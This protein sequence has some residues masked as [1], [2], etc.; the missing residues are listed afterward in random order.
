MRKLIAMLIVASSPLAAAA[1]TSAYLEAGGAQ[2]TY[3]DTA[4]VTAGTLSG[5]VNSM[6]R[7]TGFSALL[8]GSSTQNS[9]WTIFGAADGSVFT[10]ALRGLRAELHGGGSGTTYGSNTGSGQ[11]VGGAR[12]HLAGQRVGAWAGASAGTVV[13]PF[14]ARAMRMGSAAVWA[15]FGPSVAQLS[16]TPVRI[17]GG[18][19]YTDTEA[20]FRFGNARLELGAVGGF[21][22]D[23]VGYEDSP[24]S[25]AS[26]NAT[27]WLARAVG[28]TAAA[29]SY[30][31]DIGQGLPSAKYI[32]LGVRV[33]P[34]RAIPTSPQLPADHILRERVPITSDL[35]LSPEANGQRTITFR[36]PSARRVE[37]MGDFTDWAP[38]EMRAGRAPGTWV[39]TLPLGTGVRQ[40]NVRIDGGEWSVPAGLATVRDEFGGSVGVL[41][42]Q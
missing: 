33:A 38:V 15:Q 12:L 21:R 31:T 28:L 3:G 39:T 41:I 13:D 6:T 9:N 35:T 32:S 18:L 17:S 10:P 25:W 16:V 27:A 4:A 7:N 2:V 26:I 8:A 20:L 22:S 11:L 40:V 24:T 14:G 30:P 1:Q 42:V 36:A 5:A 29:G 19:D 23:V 34:K 37:I